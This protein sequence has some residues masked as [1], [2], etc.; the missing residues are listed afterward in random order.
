M[1]KRINIKGK[2][3]KDTLTDIITQLL[4][5][6][7]LEKNEKIENEKINELY[8]QI[9][10]M[11]QK[12]H[13]FIKK[14]I[15]KYDKKLKYGGGEGEDEDEG[16]CAICYEPENHIDEDGT[17]LGP[18]YKCP[19]SRCTKNIHRMCWIRTRDSFIRNISSRINRSDLFLCP[20]CRIPL[21]MNDSDLTPSLYNGILTP[22]QNSSRQNIEINDNVENAISYC[23]MLFFIF[24]LRG[25]PNL[26]YRTVFTSLI[27]YIAN[28]PLIRQDYNM[29]ML[30][31]FTIILVVFVEI[32]RDDPDV[33]A[34]LNDPDFDQ[35]INSLMAR[36]LPPDHTG[37]KRTR[38]KRTRNKKTRNKR[39]R[40]K[41]NAL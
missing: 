23:S 7:E 13:F 6:F 26:F 16:E 5:L 22:I 27:L 21:I 20:Y 39:T 30:N 4:A 32:V 36:I 41:K 17:N 31:I 15:E 1:P 40:N 12:N 14:Y 24:M 33:A 38:N 2:T 3:I 10:H 8:Q 9:V 29:F 35:L 18:L 19:N 28:L 37:G 25:A 34:F 11:V